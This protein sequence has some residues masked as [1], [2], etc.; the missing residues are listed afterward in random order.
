MY[1]CSSFFFEY[2]YNKIYTMKNLNKV[3][4]RFNILLESTMGNVKPLLSEQHDKEELISKIIDMDSE[5]NNDPIY[6]EYEKKY[7]VKKLKDTLSDSMGIDPNEIPD[8]MLDMMLSIAGEVTKQPI[9]PE[10]VMTHKDG[11]I[12]TSTQIMSMAQEGGDLDLV[13]KLQEF[14]D[15]L[16]EL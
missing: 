15:L 13:Q 8:E 4:N 11:V 10:I 12:G 7:G 14:I 3:K 16:N 2:I 1:K 6:V 5:F 9:T